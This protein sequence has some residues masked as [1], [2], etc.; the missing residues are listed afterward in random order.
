MIL[1]LGGAWQGKLDFA[2]SRFHLSSEDIFT[3]SDTQIDISKPCIYRLEEFTYACTQAGLDPV[4]QF[5]ALYPRMEDTIFIC[6]DIF[7]GVVPME[8]QLRL[9]RDATG[10]LC[11]LLAGEA[12]AVYRIYCGLEQRLK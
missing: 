6:Q 10:K 1:I 5:H 3:C 2:K 12:E 4:E 11:Q 8:R 7:C 9:W